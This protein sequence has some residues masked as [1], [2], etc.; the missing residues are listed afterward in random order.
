[1]KIL[2]EMHDTINF[3]SIKLN[4][5]GDAEPIAEILERFTK[6]AEMSDEKAP[7]KPKK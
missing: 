7:V 1:M 5:M 4:Q 2:G 6:L 3:N